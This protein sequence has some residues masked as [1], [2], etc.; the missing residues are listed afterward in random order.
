MNTNT[1]KIG[2]YKGIP[3][4]YEESEEFHLNF[5]ICFGPTKEDPNTGRTLLMPIDGG[6]GH[7]EDG[8]PH[9]PYKAVYEAKFIVINKE[10]VETFLSKYSVRIDDSIQARL[11]RQ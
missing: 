5:K 10:D 4:F 11:S 6:P 9:I 7:Y 2:E 3:I 8:N 1:Q